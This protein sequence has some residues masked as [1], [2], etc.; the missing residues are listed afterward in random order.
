[1]PC[2]I[3]CFRILD[4]IYAYVSSGRLEKG[5]EL[6]QNRNLFGFYIWDPIILHNKIGRA[7]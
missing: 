3:P 2:H 1:M 7:S 5:T 6:S 4:P